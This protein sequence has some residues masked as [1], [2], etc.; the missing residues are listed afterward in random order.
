MKLKDG[1]QTITQNNGEQ[2]FVSSRSNDFAGPVRSSTPM[3]P[4]S[5]HTFEDQLADHGSFIYRS[6]GA[7]MRPLIKQGSDL[8]VISRKPEGRC[9][10]LDVVLYKRNGHYILHRIVEVL[11]NGYVTCGDNCIEREHGITDDDIIGVMTAMVRNGR[12]ID[13]DSPGQ[14]RYALIWCAAYP[15]RT[16]FMRAKRTLGRAVRK[17][18]GAQKKS[19]APY[20]SL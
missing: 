12:R 1:F 2:V 10:P 9:K 6:V 5:S 4:T 16:P 7:S 11:P 17:A 20:A 18:R 14:Q 15:V 13:V 19:L 8:V 3:Q